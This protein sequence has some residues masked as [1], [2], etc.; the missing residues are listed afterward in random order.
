MEVGSS[1]SYPACRTHVRPCVTMSQ[2]VGKVK[3]LVTHRRV[4]H[5]VVQEV[6]RVYT[7]IQ[8]IS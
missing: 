2:S 8:L 1:Y 6:G 5:L 4:G 3:L 7:L